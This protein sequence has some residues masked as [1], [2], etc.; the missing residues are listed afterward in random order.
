MR[1]VVLCLLF[2]TSLTACASLHIHT[3]DSTGVKVS[4]GLARVPVAILTLGRSE[5]WHAHE[6]AMESWLGAYES[7]LIMAWGPPG[8]VYSDGSGGKI[9]I[10]TENR[11]YVSPGHAYTT[12]MGSA[13]G[14]AYGN[15]FSAEGSAYSTTTYTPSQVYQWQVFRQFHINSSGTIDAYSWRGL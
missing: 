11:T 8:A 12:T 6:R 1:H 14:Y 7:N 4:K 10:Y 2:L 15:T 3:D 9:F 13:T 5:I